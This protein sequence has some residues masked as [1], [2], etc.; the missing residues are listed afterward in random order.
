METENERKR[1]IFE[2]L[3]AEIRNLHQEGETLRAQLQAAQEQSSR[4]TGE[5]QKWQDEIAR[6]GTELEQQQSQFS[7]EA[8]RARQLDAKLASLT[9]DL[10]AAQ[11]AKNLTETQR[12]PLEQEKN[13]K[14]LAQRGAG[15][16]ARRGRS[17]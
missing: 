3:E 2:E 16:A 5:T 12:G 6:L 4:S 8:D 9:N 15:P 14:S 1:A 11:E 13:A 7:H 10:A 17:P